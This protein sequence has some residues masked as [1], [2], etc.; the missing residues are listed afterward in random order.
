MATQIINKNCGR[1]HKTK[2][3]GHSLQLITV[4]RFCMDVESFF[5]FFSIKRQILKGLTE[6]LG[7]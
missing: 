5:S 3:E 4:L 2:I 6:A 7:F 1:G